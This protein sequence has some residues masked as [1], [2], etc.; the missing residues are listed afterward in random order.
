VANVIGAVALEEA[1]PFHRQFDLVR[2]GTAKL[3]L[4]APGRSRSAEFRFFQ[5]IV[6]WLR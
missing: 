4:P 2:P 5:I 6:C 3:A 1:T